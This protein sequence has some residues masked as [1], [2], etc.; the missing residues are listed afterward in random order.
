ME[1][2]K[3]A[4]MSLKLTDRIPV[5]EIEI[6]TEAK[7]PDMELNTLFSDNQAFG[8]QVST[9]PSTIEEPGIVRR[10]QNEAPEH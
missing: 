7:N 6:D 4:T 5:K 1:N 8:D 10:I 3:T 9:N 2:D